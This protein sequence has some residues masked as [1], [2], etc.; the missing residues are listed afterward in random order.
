MVT[1]G[2]AGFS[3]VKTDTFV[4]T[5]LQCCDSHSDEWAFTVKGRIEYYD[6][7]LQVANCIYHHSCSGNFWSGLCTPLQFQNVPERKCRKSGQPKKKDHEQA[8][9]NICC[10]LENNFEKQL[11]ISLLRD[12][13][14][15]FLTNTDSESFGNKYLKKKLKEQYGDNVHFAEGEGLHDIV[16]MREKASQILIFYFN[17]QA[18]NKESQK[19]EIIETTY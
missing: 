13:M 14:K 19:Q 3:Y 5:I 16:K 1:P 4:K 12:K 8:F 17:T 7:D 15:E 9:I 11:T 10:Y 6:C 18:K 2:S